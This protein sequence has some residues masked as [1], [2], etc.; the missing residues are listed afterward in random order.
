MAAAP[1]AAVKAAARLDWQQV[2]AAIWHVGVAVGLVRL[3]GA[4]R[5]RGGCGR[6]PS[7]C[8]KRRGFRNW[9]S[10]RMPSRAD[11]GGAAEER[12]IDC[13]RGDGVVRPVI[14]V[15]A[16]AVCGVPPG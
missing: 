12:R 7:R 13:A 5:G 15:P 6:H 3:A 10:W 16:S 4:V 1:T 11:G 9:R 8:G 14:I 2:V